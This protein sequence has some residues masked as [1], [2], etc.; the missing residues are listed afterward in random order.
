MRVRK[1][2]TEIERKI[3]KDRERQSV[4]E[5]QKNREKIEK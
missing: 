5:R 4:T 3:E 1:R 2:Q